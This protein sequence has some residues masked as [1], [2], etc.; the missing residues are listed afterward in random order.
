MICYG[1]Y[2]GYE[3]IVPEFPDFSM[4]S[5]AGSI[6]SLVIYC[7]ESWYMYGFLAVLQWPVYFV[8]ALGKQT[9]MDR[10]HP[11]VSTEGTVHQPYLPLI[12]GAALV[13]N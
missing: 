7:N 11:L 10:R 9:W 6:T 3:L 12:H 8:A 2:G 5:P 4:V 1:N 13:Q